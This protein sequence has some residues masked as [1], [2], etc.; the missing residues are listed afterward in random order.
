MSQID[1]EREAADYLLSI[2]DELA[3]DL[4]GF[5]SVLE[6]YFNTSLDSLPQLSVLELNA[7]VQYFENIM[8]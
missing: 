2:L 5:E 8:A 4:P 3:D 1:Y 7:M 6:E